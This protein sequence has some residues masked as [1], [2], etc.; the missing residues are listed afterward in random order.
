MNTCA[1][2]HSAQAPAP[3]TPVP[4]AATPPALSD[5]EAQEE[6]THT[7]PIPIPSPTADKLAAPPT[8]KPTPAAVE[9]KAPARAKVVVQIPSTS[10]VPRDSQQTKRAPTLTPKPK[11]IQKSKMATEIWKASESA[12]SLQP[13]RLTQSSSGEAGNGGLVYQIDAKPIILQVWMDAL[14]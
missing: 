4:A 11:P 2:L 1:L 3:A 5:T 6:H 13:A 7:T 8:P 9:Q 12:Q 10:A 14:V